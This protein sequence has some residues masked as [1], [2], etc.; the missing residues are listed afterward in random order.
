[1]PDNDLDPG[2]STQMFRAFV[3]RDDGGTGQAETR[4]NRQWLLLAGL[5]AAVAVAAIIGFA[6]L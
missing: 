1:M 6:L 3:E 2:A 5:L 4:G